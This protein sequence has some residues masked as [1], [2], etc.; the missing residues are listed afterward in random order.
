M[1]HFNKSSKILNLAMFLKDFFSTN[2]LKLKQLS[3][4]KLATL[5]AQI[6]YS[7]KQK[8]LIIALVFS[9]EFY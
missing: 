5:T 1:K 7:L 3:L 6:N 9:I 2:G 8:K 4:L